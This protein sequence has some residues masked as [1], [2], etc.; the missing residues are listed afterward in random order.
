MTPLMLIL[1]L[2]LA[3][4]PGAGEPPTCPHAAAVDRR[5]DQGMGFDHHKTA[6]HFSLTSDGGTIS[7]EALDAADV[8]SREA[9]RQH[10]TH[11]AG[12]FAQGNFAMPMFIHDRM[13]PG[14][15]TMKRLRERIR[16]RVE[17]TERGARVVIRTE[18]AQA[19]R[20]VHAFLR[21]QIADHR[22]G[23]SPEP[24]R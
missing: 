11:I 6:H 15:P 10:M 17:N 20:A 16:Y 1:F 9:I 22:T 3:P 14:V 12:A 7:A 19:L 13:P 23:D 24:Q 8:E 5:G 18:D 4:A 2:G 21:F